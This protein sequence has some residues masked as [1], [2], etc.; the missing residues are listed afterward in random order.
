MD[1]VKRITGILGLCLALALALGA[2]SCSTPLVHADSSRTL[3]PPEGPIEVSDF[4][5]RLAPSGRWFDDPANGRCWTP[6]DVPADWRPYSDG[7]WIDTDYGWSW[8]SD[9]PWAWATEHYGRW[10]FDDAYGWSWVPGTDWAPAWVAWREG[11]DYLGWAPLPPS[12]RWDRSNGLA[13]KDTGD[14]PS[15][16]WCFVARS[17][18]L[19]ANLRLRVASVGRNATMLS[20][21]HDATRFEVRNGRPADVGIDAARVATY[22]GHPLKAVAIVDVGPLARGSGHPTTGGAGFYRPAVRPMPAQRA[23]ALE[24]NRPRGGGPP[25]S[26][27]QRDTQQRKLESDLSAEHRRLAHD[28]AGEL[29]SPAPGA[30]RELIRQQHA[31]EQQAFEQHATQQRRVLLQRQQNQVARPARVKSAPR[32]PAPEKSRGQQPQ[33]DPHGH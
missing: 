33:R 20:R 29:K 21:S 7:H 19:D 30:A 28:Q 5:T 23:P 12:A 10:F 18:M 9:E 6:Y 3:G 15:H 31:S 24:T 22:V 13:F 11:D 25:I 4:Y 32:N 16:E 26:Q 8:A 2:A 14:I 1:D 17:H 27:R